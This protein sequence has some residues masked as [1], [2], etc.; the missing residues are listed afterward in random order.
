M[1]WF[2]QHLYRFNLGGHKTPTP[3][4]FRCIQE[5]GILRGKK[6]CIVGLDPLPAN[7]IAT[8][9]YPVSYFTDW[10]NQTQYNKM[11]NFYFFLNK[12]SGVDKNMYLS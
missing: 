5:V 6:I 4:V 1:K 2:F 7:L 3:L 9:Y 12:A 8:L 10:T 11:L